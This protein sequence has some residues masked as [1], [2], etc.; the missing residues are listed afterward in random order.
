MAT[1][2]QQELAG[3]LAVGGHELDF[4]RPTSTWAGPAPAAIRG[5]P[6]RSAISV[7]DALHGLPSPARFPARAG[8]PGPHERGQGAPA[9]PV[10][11][12]GRGQLDRRRS[13]VSGQDPA[14]A[15]ECERSTDADLERLRRW[16]LPLGRPL[17]AVRV[18]RRT[19]IAS[20]GASSSS[21]GAGMDRQPGVTRRGAIRFAARRLPAA[22]PRGCPPSSAEV[23]RVVP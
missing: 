7:F 21:I 13:P 6:L 9:R 15:P 11:R 23:D 20:R 14:P 5:P 19:A 10:V 1:P 3:T 18:G 2:V 16:R 17:L 4:D 22:Q 12:G 8:P